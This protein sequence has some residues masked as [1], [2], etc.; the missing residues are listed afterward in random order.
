MPEDGYGDCEDSQ[1]LKRKLLVE[2]GLP[3]HA[4]RMTVVLD[5][6]GEAMRF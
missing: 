2:H 6:Q 3:R 1:L 4:L 5:E